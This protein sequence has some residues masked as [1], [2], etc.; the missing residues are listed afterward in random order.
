MRRVLIANRGEIALR[1]V[2]AC[3][4]E[5]LEAVAVYSAADRSSPHVRAADRAVAIGPASPAQS[6]LDIE[7]LIEAAREADADAVHPGYGFLAERAAFAEAV[8]AAGLVWIGPP[9]SAI[10]AMGDKTEARRRMQQAGVPIVPGA[11]A[12][13]DDIGPALGLA[14]EVGYPVM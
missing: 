4:E 5:G 6:Y 1:I 10:R 11:S 9:A 2:R 14:R 3:H 12:P 13:I 7:R 8:D